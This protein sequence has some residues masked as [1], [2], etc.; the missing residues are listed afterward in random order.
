MKYNVS[1]KIYMHFYVLFK[2]YLKTQIADI[3]FFSWKC[4]T[5]Y[6]G[7]CS[8]SSHYLYICVFIWIS[9][10][11][12]GFTNEG[13][14]YIFFVNKLTSFNTMFLQ[15]HSS[16]CKN[17]ITLLFCGFKFFHSAYTPCFLFH[18]PVW[19]TW[20]CCTILQLWTML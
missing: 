12:L 13:K 5:L 9:I 19:N 2:N 3:F 8:S 7:S 17:D 4:Y 14:C 6:S 15:S 10:E 11:L 16:S 18:A 20:I 1:F